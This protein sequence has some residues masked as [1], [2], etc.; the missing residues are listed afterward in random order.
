MTVIFSVPN[1][2]PKVFYTSYQTFGIIF[3]Y[4]IALFVM[5][6]LIN[7]GVGKKDTQS[8]SKTTCIYQRKRCMNISSLFFLQIV[9][10]IK[11]AKFE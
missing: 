8:T 2:K 10:C 11:T 7:A 6:Y 1:L 9:G 5:M 4:E 3:I